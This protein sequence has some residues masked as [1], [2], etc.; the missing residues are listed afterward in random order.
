MKRFEQLY[1]VT[2]TK[3]K[4]REIL[5]VMMALEAIF[6]FSYFG[7]PEFSAVSTTT[8]HILVIVAAMTLGIEGSVPVVCVFALTSIWNASYATTG[9]DQLFSPF[10]SGMPIRSLMLFLTRVLF[11]IL[12]SCGFG[13]YFRKL[14]H[15]VYLGISVIAILST[16]L[17][18]LMILVAY[19]VLFP[20]LNQELTVNLFSLPIFRDWMSYLLAAVV[21]CSVH[22]MLS[23][24]T[25][26]NHLSYLCENQ[27]PLQEHG[28]H[29]APTYA[30]IGIAI[31]MVLC[32]LYLRK[33]IFIELQLE[34]ITLSRPA[35][36]HISAYLLQL[37][38]AFLC[39]IGIVSILI[40]WINEYYRS[41]QLKMDQKL[42]EQHVKIS[43]DSLTGALSRFAYQDALV[44]YKHQISDDFVVFMMDINGLK[45]VND[46]LGHEAGNELI[47]GAAT[48]IRKAVGGNG[49]TFRVG[50]DE[51]VVLGTMKKPQAE[52][53]LAALER[54]TAAWSGDKVKK[55]RIAAGYA[56]AIEF[57]GYSVESLIKVAD[58]AMYEQKKEYYRKKEQESTAETAEK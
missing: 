30:K 36:I 4:V 28:Y 52:Q 55:L 5:F 13:L 49:R 31:I 9:F 50:G 2:L 40:L 25:V 19:Y 26:R 8:L 39:L 23:R 32:V 46:S 57:S 15:H 27:E 14:H 44:S 12:V 51:F 43:I 29:G 10:V 56:L 45:A 16:L 6:A 18:G 38:C 35:Y 34:G 7:Y 24:K 20:H 42:T 33:R 11:A 21:C 41:L 22:Y 48:C 3:E 58:Q 17:H 54:I 47:C 1:G 37:L 53:T